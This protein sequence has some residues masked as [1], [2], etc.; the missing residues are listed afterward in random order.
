MITKLAI[1]DFTPSQELNIWDVRDAKSY[2]TG[3]IQ[4]AI[5]HPIDTLNDTL[6]AQTTGD[7]YVLCGGG[8]KAKRACAL[9][10]ELQPNRKIIHLTGGTRGAKAA[11]MPIIE[12]A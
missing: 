9:L 7:I 5:N 8:T 10:D 6:L 11:G 2:A 1:T 4:Y 3:H 12:E